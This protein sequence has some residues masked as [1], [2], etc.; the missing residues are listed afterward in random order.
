[1]LTRTMRLEGY[2]GLE[3]LCTVD[4]IEIARDGE[5]RRESFKGL[6]A[7]HRI[8]ALGC[9]GYMSAETFALCSGLVDGQVAR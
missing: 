5:T 4:G 6:D 2:E 8:V 1:M 9:A 3:V 7:A